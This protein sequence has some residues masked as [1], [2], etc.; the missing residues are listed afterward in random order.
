[1]KLY[2]WTSKVSPTELLAKN[3]AYLNTVFTVSLKKIKE[4]G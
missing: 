2:F 4:T 1:M 3:S